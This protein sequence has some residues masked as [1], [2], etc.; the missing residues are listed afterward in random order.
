M[1]PEERKTEL[2]AGMLLLL[3]AVACAG[4]AAQPSG[5]LEAAAWALATWFGAGAMIALVR[6][7]LSW[8]R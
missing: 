1:T 8:R 7:A 4:S 6:L 3:L 5:P 2:G